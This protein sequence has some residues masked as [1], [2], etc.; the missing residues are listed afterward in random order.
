MR[1]AGNAVMVLAAAC[2]LAW[3]AALAGQDQPIVAVFRIEDRTRRIRSVTLETL[4][5]HL[6]NRLG[7]GGTFKIV[8]PSE[9]KRALVSKKTESYR[10]CYEQSCQIEIG[11]ELAAGKTLSTTMSRIGEI[12]MVG[13]R[14]Y[15]LKKM[16]TD[17][18]ATAEGPCTPAGLKKS[19][20]SVASQIRAWGGGLAD[21]AHLPPAGDAKPP[22]VAASGEYRRE[23]GKA[24]RRLVASVR[25]GTAEEKLERYQQFLADYPLDNPHAAEVQ[26][27]IDALE[28]RLEQEARA[29]RE[30]E[31]RKAA[32]EAGRE[33]AR[34]IKADYDRLKA[35]KGSAS[36]KLAAWERF[37]A[38]YPQDNPYLGTAERKIRTL[39][40]RAEKEARQTA[41][42]APPGMLRIPAGEFWMGCNDRIDS[43]CEAD[44]KPGRKVYLDA[45]LIDRTEVTVEQYQRCVAAGACTG[46]HWDDGTCY[47]FTGKAWEQGRLPEGFRGRT[48]PV[49]CV[50]WGQASAYC[51][52]SGNRL[53]TEAEWEKA[54]RGNDGRKYPWGNQDA[55]C[56][57]AVMNE[58][59]LGCGRQSTWPVC[60]KERG[61]SPYGLC[62]MAGNV[63]EWV[64]DWYKADY[65]SG[66]PSRNPE[67]AAGG[68]FRVLR[69]GGWSSVD[70]GDLRAS[71]RDG[72]SPGD[73]ICSLGFRC[74]RPSSP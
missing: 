58:G 52:W 51:G 23:L 72:G 69:G 37:A 8:P 9:I 47:V 18:T 61:K 26:K 14:L 17:T 66:A 21:D 27:A 3:P 5:E 38:D 6:G 45:Y 12:C 32:L 41:A 68:P 15:D 59:G 34:R 31:E 36:E 16:A 35:Q 62:D 53:P 42:Q 40:E 71:L 43:S 67:G 49:V 13:S 46:P 20:E 22:P 73:R 33:R 24:W 60:S 44:E 19:I 63:W 10:K 70:A 30:A 55:S 56:A 74:A 48:Q 25:K 2:V 64:A 54:A 57:Y 11:Q 4:T 29:R 65:Y 50:D 39:K 1:L 7:R 28:A